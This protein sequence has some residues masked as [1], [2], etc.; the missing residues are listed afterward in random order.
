MQLPSKPKR[1]VAL[2]SFVLAV[3]IWSA[4][5]IFLQQPIRTLLILAGFVLLFVSAILYFLSSKE[6][7]QA[8]L[9]K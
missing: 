4:A 3:V 1:R 7:K 9:S 6:Q 2:I 5:D 8:Q